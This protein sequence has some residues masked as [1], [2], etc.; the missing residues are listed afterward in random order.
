MLRALVT[1]TPIDTAP[2]KTIR[3]AEAIAIKTVMEHEREHGAEIEDVS[4]PN[5][6]KGFDLESRRPDGEVRYI[7]VKGCTGVASV[8]L[9]ANVR[10]ASGKSSRPLL[11]L[12]R[13][14]LRIESAVVPMP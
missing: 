1:P 10:A 5:L 6:K 7:E 9:T 11:A 13:L 3:D 2:T 8:E 12:C 14:S 4:N